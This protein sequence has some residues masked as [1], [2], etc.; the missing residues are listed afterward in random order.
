[1]GRKSAAHS[2]AILNKL[3]KHKKSIISAP[4]QATMVLRP[5]LTCSFFEFGQKNGPKMGQ[6]WAKKRLKKQTDN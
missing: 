2:A 5:F 3:S 4:E 6:K 1:M